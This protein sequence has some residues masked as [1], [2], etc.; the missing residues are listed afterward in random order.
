MNE[1]L[2]HELEEIPKAE[3]LIV[4]MPDVGLVGLIASTYLVKEVKAG[5]V[6][7]LDSQHLPPVIQYHEAKPYPVMRV[8]RHAEEGRKHLLL[9]SEVPFNPAGYQSFADEL[10]KW[11]KS[12]EVNRTILLGG[13]PTPQRMKLEKPSVYCAGVTED[14]LR[15][16]ERAGLNLFKEG[17]VSGPYAQILKE[18]FKHSINCVA[19]FAESF[20]NYPDP[21]AAAA[22]I[23]ALSSLTGIK[24]SVEPLLEQEEEIRVKLRETMKRTMETMQESGKAYEYTVPAMYL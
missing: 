5:V 23:L 3:H 7:Y 19:L 14:D 4:G 18:C 20:L 11:I 12:K 10:I 15:E 16:I 9:V 8:H 22:V 6:A 2:F 17:Y 13:V 1:W 21:G 24:V